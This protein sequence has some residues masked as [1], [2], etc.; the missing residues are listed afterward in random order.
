MDLTGSTR[1]PD[2]PRGS[3]RFATAHVFTGKQAHVRALR[4]GG[5]SLMELIVVVAIMLD[6]ILRVKRK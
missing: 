1:A 5:F 4:N 3:G 2:R 6:R